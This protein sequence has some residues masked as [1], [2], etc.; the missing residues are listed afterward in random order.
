M[1]LITIMVLVTMCFAANGQ[2]QNNNWCFG[3]NGGITFNTTPPTGFLSAISV[4]ESTATVSDRHTGKLLF[5]TNGRFIFD[6]SHKSMLNSAFISQESVYSTAQGIVIVPFINDTT[7]YYVFT[8]S[9]SPGGATSSDG[10]LLYS[11]V[12]MTLNG[13]LGAVILS[14][15][16]IPIDSGL[17]EAMTTVT[18]CDGVWVIVAK[19][20]TQNYQAYQV[21]ASGVNLNPVISSVPYANKAVGI[22]SIKVSPNKKKL[23]LTSSPQ[24]GNI[25]F[26]SL[27][28]FDVLTGTVTHNVV[29]EAGL[30]AGPRGYYGC[31][32][33]PD[34]KKLYLSFRDVYQ[35]D[36]SLP[37][38]SDIVNSKATIYTSNS[39]GVIGLQLGPDDN[40]YASQ[41]NKRALDRITNCNAKAP[42]CVYTPTVINLVSTATSRIAL[43]QLVEYAITSGGGVV[44]SRTD[45]LVCISQPITLIA[46]GGKDDYTWQDGSK[47]NLFTTRNEGTFWVRSTDSSCIHAVDTFVVKGVRVDV[48]IN[49]D[50]TICKGEVITLVSNGQEV[51]AS[52]LWSNGST[53]TSIN[54]GAEGR[55]LL[56]VKYLGCSDSDEVVVTQYPLISIDLGSD[57]Q[58][59]K[60]NS[61][62]LPQ[63]A[64]SGAGDKYLWQ[65]GSNG[66]TFNVTTAGKYYVTLSNQCQTISDSII[67]TDR[68]CHFFFPSAFTPNGDGRNDIARLVGD[69]ATVR[70][71]KLSIFNRWG[72]RVFFTNDVTKGW[73]GNYKK[74]KAEFGAYYYQ[75][76]YKYSG[77][78]ELM[79][80]T[81]MMVR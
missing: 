43:P 59:C 32:F 25:G 72:E 52:Y 68:N 67:I 4:T 60:G 71:Y 61:F 80:G 76:Q 6:A 17:I 40:I 55:Y 53:D 14:Q 58:I 39:F 51:G 79:K 77:D 2:K 12:D 31:E 46:Q 48:A 23:C 69:V 30:S 44:T 19:R 36:L 35:L 21:T 9:H 70:D 29:I 75:I 1:R 5:Y 56:T 16:A 37:S 10:K 74:Q 26:A 57:T 64:T 65:D 11:V 47:T 20:S 38:N 13:G 45:T 49:E 22:A 15:R 34:S 3:Y 42:A 27:N 63:I 7:K 62:T 41:Y 54:V 78:K 18:T 33:S 8:L 81:I 66:R 28:D 73:D 24:T 50:T